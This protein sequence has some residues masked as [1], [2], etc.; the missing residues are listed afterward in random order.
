MITI[1]LQKTLDSA[2]GTMALDLAVSLQQGE[3]IA[4]NG[5][6]GAGKTSL[7]RM[8]AGFMNPDGGNICVEG[9]TW[10]NKDKKI[11]IDA[12]KRDIGFVF[13]DHALFPN[14]SVEGNLRFA[15]AK[16]Q[17]DR[18]VPEL[19]EM[20]ELG[21]LRNSHPERLSGGQKQ[22]VAL[23]RAL[24]RRPKLLMLDEP[25]AALDPAMRH[26]I[27][28]LLRTAHTEYG[29][30][31]LMVSHDVA[32]IYTLASRVLVMEA[33]KITLDGS[34]DK[35]FT[36]RRISGKFQ[37]TGQ[38]LKIEQEDIVYVV[39]VQA[40]NQIVLVVVSRADVTDLL[41][42]DKVLVSSKAFNPMIIRIGR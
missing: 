14:M 26:K 10:F 17:D 36:D 21:E 34:P 42:G 2:Q 39:T 23:A 30:T 15:L 12:R 19:I 41:V 22:R 25:L 13:Q 35:V 20:M 32:E 1:K 7:L 18:I 3:F 31:T 8:T 11:N 27:Q 6:S 16:G 37:V 29:L 24:V 28:N 33:G 40:F 9:D 5:P 4:V 38:V